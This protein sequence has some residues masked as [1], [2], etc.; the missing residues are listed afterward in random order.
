[1]VR[2][3]EDHSASTVCTLAVA[4]LRQGGCA[5]VRLLEAEVQ[6]FR[7][8]LAGT[9]VPPRGD[10]RHGKRSWNASFQPV[11]HNSTF[12]EMSIEAQSA[13]SHRRKALAAF[14]DALREDERGA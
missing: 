6:T 14:V 8:E 11:G 7:G 4:D 12:G 13:M 1:M 9:V 10:V 3:F 2:R 5:P